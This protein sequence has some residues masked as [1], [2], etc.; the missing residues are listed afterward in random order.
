MTLFDPYRMLIKL[1]LFT[2][3]CLFLTHSGWSQNLSYKSVKGVIQHPIHP[4]TCYHSQKSEPSKILNNNPRFQQALENVS[5]RLKATRPFQNSL[6]TSEIIINFSANFNDNPQARDAFRFAADMWEMEIVSS[7][8]IVIDADFRDLGAGVIAQNGSNVVS[9][10]PNAPDPTVV[11]VSSLGNAI[12]GEDLLPGQPDLIQT[13]NSSFN[14]YYGLDASPPSNQTDFVTIAFHEIGHGLG[15]TGAANSGEGVGRGSGAF[16]NSWDTFVELINGTP[17]LD[18][19]FGSEAQINALTGGALFISSFGVNDALNGQRAR[20]FAPNPF[21]PGSSFSHWDESTFPTGNPN[22]LMT[23]FNSS[24]EAIHDVG[25][26]TRAILRDM[27]WEL[28]SG[29]DFDLGIATIASPNS[30]QGLSNESVT[31]VVGNLGIQ[32]VSNIPVSYKVN[33]GDWVTEILSETILPGEE[34]EYTFVVPADLSQAGQTYTITAKVDVFVDPNQSN[35][36]TFKSVTHL[37]PITSFPYDESFES[38]AAQWVV[39]G[40]LLWQLGIPNGS[41]INS[42]S[43]GSNAWVTNLTGNYPNETTAFLVSP[44]FDFSGKQD[45]RLS[46]DIWYDIEFAWDGVSLQSSTDNGVNW[47][48]IGIFG[49]D[50]DWYTD[51]P[52]RTAASDGSEGE[53]GIDALNEA[54]SDGNGWT[55]TGTTGSG[56]YIRVERELIG[57]GDE[58]VIFR[59][60]F[61]SDQ[62][63]NN[64]GFAFDNISIAANDQGTNDVGVVELI[65]PTSGNLTIS[66]NITVLV[67]NFGLA[68]ASGF[69]ISYQ[70]DGD[71]II[72]ETFTGSLAPGESQEFT[73]G[74]SADLSGLQTYTIRAFTGLSNDDVESNDEITVQIQNLFTVSTFPYQESFEVDAGGWSSGGTNSSWALGTPGGSEIVS[75]SN[76]INAWATN[77]TGSYNADEESYLTSPGFNLTSL[78]NPVMAFDLWSNADL[79][80]GLYLEASTDNGLTWSVVT[81]ESALNWTNTTIS[82]ISTWSGSSSGYRTAFIELPYVGEEFVL[83]R[84]VFQSDSDN[85][86]EGFALDNIR[87]SDIAN[88]SYSLECPSDQSLN[89]DSQQPFATVSLLNP[90]VQNGSGA[91]TITNT[92]N[93]SADASDSYFVGE[94]IV[95]FI[96]DVDGELSICETTI[97]V[98]DNEN[99]EIDCVD[100][101]VVAVSSGTSSVAVDYPL[102]GVSDNFGFLNQLTYSTDQTPDG[103]SGVACPTGPNSFIRTFDL[104]N[105]FGLTSGFSLRSVDIGLQSTT[106]EIPSTVNI[107]TLDAL[108]FDINSSN[109]FI[110]DNLDLI[111]SVD[112]TFAASLSNALINVPITAEITANQIVVLEFF[113][114]LGSGDAENPNFF[115]GA[116]P[117]QTGR[118][119]LVGP[120]CGINEPSEVDLIGDGFPDSQWVMNLNGFSVTNGEPT[121]IEGI[122]NGGVFSLGSS[123]EVYEILDAQ[124]NSS[125]CSFDVTVLEATL[126]APVANSG[127]A[128]SGNQFTASWQAISGVQFYQLFV[129]EDNFDTYIDGYNG[130]IINGL[131]EVVSNL[132][133]NRAYYYQVRAVDSSTPMA[134]SLFSNVIVTSTTIDVPINLVSNDTT[135]VSFIAV[136]QNITGIDEYLIDVSSDNFSTFVPEYDSRSVLG[137]QIEVDGLDPETEYQWRVKAIND[138]GES[139][140]SATVTPVTLPLTPVAITA[141]DLQTNGFTANWNNSGAP[142]YLVDVTIDNFETFV[143]GYESL[144]INTN[145]LE[146]VGLDPNQTYRYRVRAK[147]NDEV[148]SLNSNAIRAST[149]AAVPLALDPDQVTTYGFV[150]RW[151]ESPNV[152]TYAID[153]T[154]NDFSQPLTDYDNA[155][156]SDNSILVDDLSAGTYSY[157]VRAVNAQGLISDNS[158]VISVVISESSPEQPDDPI[159]TNATEITSSSFIANWNNQSDAIFYQL[160]VSGDNFTTFENLPVKNI[161][162]TSFLIDELNDRTDYSYRVRAFN[163]AGKSNYSNVINL[164]TITSLNSELTVANINTYPNPAKAQLFINAS[165]FASEIKSLELVDLNGRSKVGVNAINRVQRNLYE[166]PLERL[167]KGIYILRIELPGDVLFKR[168]VKE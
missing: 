73:F 122:G 53:D 133:P 112:F 95:D 15:I 26:I 67:Q 97:S 23:P 161:F 28:A 85:E 45:P 135:D 125:Q 141:T 77:L 157:R 63:V 32:E 153:V 84:F 34:V 30:G 18:L 61:A 59:L 129:S 163:N 115:P 92:Y 145:S 62:A 131:N 148:L 128:I 155:F 41:V 156:V 1:L 6:A 160:E 76:G 88:V 14:F 72:T 82:Q 70:I 100:E 44:V 78:S 130:K 118:S 159:A 80:D 168:I 167:S 2:S 116:N 149:A 55:G 19:T 127:T 90:I 142:S 154:D 5:D 146:I 25:D 126:D 27:G 11:Y 111:A 152:H 17:I 16:P 138:G 56:G 137:N 83:F 52:S 89:T 33:D 31:V 108:I 120:Q 68:S 10:V 93:N 165:S 132:S 75:A 79:T 8:P 119:Y 35:N 64:E 43:D 4:D 98:S 69:D 20:I 66:E 104:E 86:D 151:E 91:V 117:D 39:D 162:A 158:N 113:T 13:Y 58:T 37:L 94:T 38:G 102:P 29:V 144:E 42:A 110:F 106:V 65:S 74:A 21:D 49:N 105:D 7:V 47:S 147:N 99:P 166:L 81:S 150:A 9:N 103:Q 107:Y 124:G 121:L 140:F 46:M 51:G 22:S 87:L 71:P 109:D 60:V 36:E 54:V 24:G 139:A 57:L 3:F 143:E 96:V 101:I 114:E 164:R 123:T 134:Y 12:A 48:T 50:V 136:W 40:D